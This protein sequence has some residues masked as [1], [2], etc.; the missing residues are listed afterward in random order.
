MHHLGATAD[1]RSAATT[2]PCRVLLVDDEP[3]VLTTYARVL[4]RDGYQ[5]VTAETV[6]DATAALAGPVDVVITDMHLSEGTGLEVLEAV[7]AEQPAT[8]VLFLTGATEVDLAVRALEHGALRWLMKPVTPDVL[9]AAI[10]SS[11]RVARAVARGDRSVSPRELAN[12]DVRLDA[13]LEGLTLVCQPI[14]RWSTRRIEAF[15]VLMRTREAS[16]RRPERLL[17]AAE[18]LGRLHDVG[19]AV[20]RRAAGFA[21][22][23]TGDVS[24]HVN[25]HPLDLDDPELYDLD[26]PLTEVATCVVLELTERAGLDGVDDVAGKIAALRRLGFRLALDDLGGG[27]ASLGSVAELRPDAVKLDLS[28]CQGVAD[29][30]TRRVLVETVRGLCE[31]TGIELVCEGVEVEADLAAL[32][33]LGC[34]LFQGYLFARPSA[35]PGEVPWDRLGAR[36]IARGTPFPDAGRTVELGSVDDVAAMLAREVRATLERIRADADRIGDDPEQIGVDIA[37]RAEQA[38]S[39]LA[40]LLDLVERRRPTGAA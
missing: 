38:S 29:D 18:R 13:A 20:R 21:R 11:R 15:E 26:A 12:L 14:C 1:S 32:V 8:P 22:T 2:T 36:P 37:N 24:L 10:E 5:V 16:L 39:T 4:R 40:A 35:T 19:R 17:A 3:A 9:R 28:L 6:A 25:L 23:L 31:R 7:R 27:Y 30:P 33:G 34:D